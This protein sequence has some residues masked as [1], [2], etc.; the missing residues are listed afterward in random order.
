VEKDMKFAVYWLEKSVTDEDPEKM[1]TLGEHFRVGFDGKNVRPVEAFS[2][3]QK[4]ME[5][6][7]VEAAY[8]VAN[9]YIRGFGVEKTPENDTK[10]RILYRKLSDQYNHSGSQL[11]VGRCYENGIGCEVDKT[12]PPKFFRKA[13]EQNHPVAQF[14]LGRCYEEGIGVK[15]NLKEAKSWFQKWAAHGNEVARGKLR[16]TD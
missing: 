15:K 4:A 1:Y 16:C 3:F 9:C 2:W 12:A 5:L 10:A 11:E 8:K 13:A 7:H 6:G 14:E